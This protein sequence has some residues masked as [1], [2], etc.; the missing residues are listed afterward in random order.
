MQHN[1][2]NQEQAP[3]FDLRHCSYA[4][5]NA[6][7]VATLRLI[8]SQLRQRYEN[9]ALHSISG[10]DPMPCISDLTLGQFALIQLHNKPIRSK[11]KSTTVEQQQLK[12]PR[13]EWAAFQQAICNTSVPEEEE[14]KSSPDE[15]EF[16]FH[17]FVSNEDAE[18]QVEEDEAEA[19]DSVVASSLPPKLTLEEKRMQRRHTRR[20]REGLDS[21]KE[22]PTLSLA[23]IRLFLH[24]I[25][26]LEH[27]PLFQI[28][29][30]NVDAT[31]MRLHDFAFQYLFAEHL[32]RYK[33]KKHTRHIN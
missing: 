33:L 26:H 19:K 4:A 17:L 23:Q 7:P 30:V 14:D 22:F 24:M 16:P 13:E 8:W 11:S 25:R 20:L 12:I 27:F 15:E 29:G 6:I 10:N 21:S 31:P 32:K 28:I 2:N 3:Q 1:N 9:V 5:K 18:Q